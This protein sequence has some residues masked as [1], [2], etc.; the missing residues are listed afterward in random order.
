MRRRHNS[1]TWRRAYASA[2]PC[3]YSA[4]ADGLALDGRL[5][6][7]DPELAAE[8]FLSLIIGSLEYRSSA[9]PDTAVDVFLRAYGK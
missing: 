9:A 8:H 4:L 7:C 5:R 3:G 2:Q 1:P 6:G